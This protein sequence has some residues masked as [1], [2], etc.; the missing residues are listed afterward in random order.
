M[1]EFRIRAETSVDNTGVH[2]IIR[3]K[4]YFQYYL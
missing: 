1:A 3:G 2:N 4:R